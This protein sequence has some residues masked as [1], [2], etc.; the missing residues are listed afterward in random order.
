MIMD[1]FYNDNNGHIATP[2][3]DSNDNSN[4]NSNSNKRKIYQ[5]NSNSNNN[6]SMTPFQSPSSTFYHSDGTL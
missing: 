5:D 1:T 2:R 3:Q 6:C 4:S